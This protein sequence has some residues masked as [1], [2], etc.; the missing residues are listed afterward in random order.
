MTSFQWHHIPMEKRVRP[1]LWNA[2]NIEILFLD[3]S[4]DQLLGERTVVCGPEF[5]ASLCGAILMQ[6]ARKWVGDRAYEHALR[7]FQQTYTSAESLVPLATA[8][9][10]DIPSQD[11]IV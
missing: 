7:E 11:V 9:T 2:A 6:S 1:D 8:R 10:L 4:T 5:T 3:A